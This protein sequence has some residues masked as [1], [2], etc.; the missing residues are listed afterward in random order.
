MINEN[1]LIL[2]IETKTMSDKPNGELDIHRVTGMFSYPEN[3][4]SISTN[5]SVIQ[6]N[7]SKHRAIIGHN[8]SEYDQP[9]LVRADIDFNYKIII[10]TLKIAKKRLKTLM[11]IEPESYS[12][13]NL[14]EELNLTIMKGDIDY[15]VFKKKPD[16]WTETEKKEIIKYTMGDVEI[17][18]ELFELFYNK[19]FVFRQFVSEKNQKNMS[20]LTCSSG[21]LSYKI[22]CNFAGLEEKYAHNVVLT[23]EKVGGFVLEPT[24][25]EYF[26][27]WYLD[28]A[29]LYPQIFMMFNLF[30]NPTLRPDCTDWFTGNNVFEIKGKYAKDT[31]HI[32]SLK[33]EYMFKERKK[34]KK[35]D[36]QLAYAYKII[37]NG[38]YGVMRSPVFESTYYEYTGADC[39]RVGQ[40]MN[41][42]IGEFF[43]RAGFKSVAGDTDSRFLV[44][45][46]SLSI[47]EQKALLD[48]TKQELIDFI[49][50]NVP[51]PSDSFD[52]ESETGDN[53]V[54]YIKFVK[55]INGKKMLKKNYLYIYTDEKTNKD[56]LEIKG[57]PIIKG[58]ATKLGKKLLNEYI[59][60]KIL[61]KGI[62]SFS[63]TELMAKTKELLTENIS[64]AAVTFKVQ[65]YNTYK[66][67]TCIQANISRKFF[68]D[69]FG[70]VQLIKNKRGGEI[71][72]TGA[73]YCSVKRA[74]L[75]NVNDI[76]LEKLENEIT[77]FITQKVNVQ[78]NLW[79]I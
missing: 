21:S 30:G 48:K 56:K 16:E 24:G 62:C 70:T 63:K 35:S 14:A 37:L 46:G 20:W 61:E 64:L 23:K 43:D 22:L 50:A 41:M 73:H 76:I 10:D 8:I 60:P 40:K 2:D 55:D 67:K 1:A 44:Y 52:L 39:C 42:L 6:E 3:K 25:E 68:S 9:V 11:R 65:P 47:P 19:F 27:V 69:S 75:L 59:K 72:I 38:G 26:N 33:Y 32:L 7:I 15:N 74:D 36:P 13:K 71:Q 45:L 53:P 49:N 4:K 12:L 34:V 31:P 17:T 54:K 18:K 58:N 57:M 51:F 28:F 78:K 79:Q 66:S 29:S 5:L 77:P